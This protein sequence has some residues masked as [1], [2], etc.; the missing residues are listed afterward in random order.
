MTL[1]N[2][3]PLNIIIAILTLA[4]CLASPGQA[5]LLD[6]PMTG[7]TAPGWVIGGTAYLTASTGIDP[8]GNGWLRLTEP[9]DNQS[10]FAMYDS[11][12]DISQGVVIQFDYATWGG[13][14]ADG[15][16]IYLFD[17]AYNAAT[18][19]VGA[20][21]GS[22]GYDKKTVAPI[23]PGLSGG[24]I[25]IG[26][27]EFG[28]FSSPT[29]G[30]IG[31][32][33]AL[34]NS[35]AV[36]GPYDHPSGAY[37]YLG[38]TAANVGTLWFNQTFRPGQ[39]GSQYRKVVIYLTPVA[40]P[41]YM[42]VDVFMQ[43]GYN[44]PLTYL[45]NT[46]YTMR[47]IP[48][49]VKVGYAASTG[50]STNYH[51]IRNLAIDNLPTN[52]NLA[53]AKTA[54][55]PTVTP[56]GALTYTVTARN[57]GPNLVTIANNVSIVDTVPAALTGVIWTCAGSGGGICGAVSGSGN[58]IN[59]TATLPFNGAAT[60][61]ITG[62]VAAGTPL[63]TGLVNTATLTPPTG[64]TDYLP[65]DNSASVTTT[66]VGTTVTISGN[67]FHDNGNGAGGI[68][69]NGVLD[70]T[71]ALVSRAASGGTTYFAKIY[72]SSDLTTALQAVTVSTTGTFTFTNIP[73][74]GTYTII[75]ST[76]NATNTF[77]PSFPNANWI[78]TSPID[79]TRSNVVTT[80]SNLTNQNFGLYNGSRI[81]GKVIKDDGFN[82]AVATAN[83]AILNAAEVGIAGVTMSLRNS[84]NTVTYD[85]TTTNSDGNFALFTN[86]ASATLRIYENANPAGYLSVNA[87]VGNTVG[88]YT[89][90]GEYISFAYT[91][92]GNNA[93]GGYRN[94]I[95]SDV[96]GNTF[97]PTPQAQNGSALLPVDYAHTFTPGSGGSLSL[98]VNSRTQGTWPAIIYYR[99]VNCNSAYDAG[100][101]VISGVF[102]VFAGVPVCILVRDTIPLAAA[103]GTTDAVVTRATFTYTN[104]QGPVTSTHNVTDTTTVVAPGLSTSTKT[105]IDLNG[106]DSDPG[107]I[108]RYTITVTESNSNAAT[109]VSVTDNIP[110]NV[111]TFTVISFPAGATNSST[112]SGT[113]SN[114]SGYLNITGITV[115]AGG[116]ITI[117][118]DVTIATGTPIGTPIDNSAAV[119]NPA[120]PGGNPVA[121]QIIV[122]GSI[123]PGSG[124]KQL[125]L[126]GSAGRPLSRMPTPNSAPHTAGINITELN[127][128]VWTLSPTLA[129]SSKIDPLL[130][131]TVPVDL[132][133]ARS[134]STNDR[135]VTVSLVCSSGGTTLTNSRTFTSAQIDTNAARYTFA[136]PLATAQ[137][138]PTNSTWN[139]TVRNASSGSGTRDIL[140]YPVSSGNISQVIL[141]SSTVINIDSI[142]YYDAA[143]PLGNS[144]TSV[145][146]GQTVYIR[147]TVS[148]P[149]GSYDIN[150]AP[151]G[152]RPTITIKNPGGTNIVTAA[153]MTE[154]GALTTTGTKTFEYSAGYTIPGVG[155]TGNWTVRVDAVEGTEGT[156]TDFGI[157]A[158]PV[159]LLMPS[160]LVVK[161]AQPYSDPVNGTTNPKAIP[162]AFVTYTIQVINSGNGA[163]DNNTTVITDPIPANTELFVGDFDGAGPGLG[164]ILFTNGSTASGLSYTFTNL[165]STTDNLAFSGNNGTDYNKNNTT[166]DSNGCDPTVTNI[167]IPLNGVFNG[168]DGTNHPSF[169]VKFRVRIQ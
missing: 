65:S 133:L 53:I 113:G 13:N 104:S 146:P 144:I 163:V 148:D 94:I 149:F 21:G 18:F 19:N 84:A 46:L 168:S 139:L 5:A 152:T 130:S 32:P 105:V 145:A 64:I 109:G 48:N 169:N 134:S 107:D 114:G 136:L 77:N 56:G 98:A 3:N 81:S 102:N 10:G 68:A 147:A 47:P 165:T 43:F 55:T 91:L 25:G 93:T 62:T 128:L 125:Y 89:I 54:S 153:A 116:S 69:Y 120:G 97:A 127:Q 39:L 11:S 58:S 101:T 12:F 41:Q 150:A 86:T 82:G 164:P 142:T 9:T 110:A 80:G 87:N 29:E 137:T 112:G 92:Y 140:V 26:I 167:K 106:G 135:I 34:A 37:Y 96:P 36:R 100:D 63:G 129:G 156:V 71:E 90:A 119:N 35:V 161:S 44:Q 73:S 51:E 50:G 6:Q 60:Y 162:G 23:A 45:I 159:V 33:G 66:V 79:Y 121:P 132:Y 131:A 61:T 76:T 95:F 115:P 22:L 24:Y 14:G 108:L 160:L 123:V 1:K 111:N 78:Y 70:G 118:F 126:Y 30:R 31:G 166:P 7:A 141:P 38:G 99:D 8:P 67:V 158:L 28:N 151:P 20:S 16:S 57:Y 42:R 4:V 124:N 83:D 122:S 157:K 103:N 52:I 49:T 154:L 155:S 72:R 27:D 138:C 40:A 17:G 75:L 15:Y 74:H 88:T 2:R 85:T 59:T 117:V 143:Y